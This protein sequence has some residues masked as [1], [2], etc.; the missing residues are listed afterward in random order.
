[1]ATNGKLQTFDEM[2]NSFFLICIVIEDFLSY[3][4]EVQYFGSSYLEES[5]KCELVIKE[6]YWI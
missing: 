6:I 5:A 2:S 3:Q 1:M 4:L